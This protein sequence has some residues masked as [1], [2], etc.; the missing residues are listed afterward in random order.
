MS[1]IKHN[2]SL[3]DR[4][5]TIGILDADLL[6]KGTRFPN[7]ALMKISSYLKT[8]GYNVNL[9]LNYAGINQVDHIYLS[10]VFS[11]TTVPPEIT[12]S[13]KITAGGTGF[14]FDKAPSLPQD[15]EHC[16]PDYH[17]Y[18]EFVERKIKQGIKPIHFKNYQDGSIGFTTRGC[19]RKCNFCVNRN[20][21]KVSRHSGI[22]EFLDP[23]RKYIYLLDDNVLG[24]SE[25]EEIFEEL[26]STNKQFQYK[27]GLDMR[28]MTK[29]KANILSNSKYSGD[30]IF[31]FDSIKD[32]ELMLEKLGIWRRH[33]DKSTKFY[34]ICA[35]ESVKEDDIENVFRRIVTLMKFR[36][37]PYVIRYDGWEKSQHSGMYIN[38][39]RWCNQPNIFKKKSFRDFCE[40]NGSNSS[41]MRYLNH[42]QDNYPEIAG[43]YF[44]LR[45]DQS[46][47]L[48]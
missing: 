5:C 4:E 17:L 43:K 26:L 10:K 19:F 38:L 7:L 14:F 28:L 35:Y 30:F 25:W 1:N 42:F 29:E 24:S 48:F 40:A 27:Q 8:K 16:V 22:Y 34:L 39:A 31:A 47:K 15:I 18:D 45:Y 13:N 2:F 37:L 36:C 33:T 32:E 46:E 21:N 20:S 11:Y 44:D 3:P 41:A 9:M 23:K 6:D 12:S